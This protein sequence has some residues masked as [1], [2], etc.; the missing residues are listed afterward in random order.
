MRELLTIVA[1][2]FLMLSSLSTV[3][4]GIGYLI[5]IDAALLVTYVQIAGVVLACSVLVG[6]Y[7]GRVFTNAKHWLGLW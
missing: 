5:G 4:L 7:D 6:L 1:G 2:F 3:L